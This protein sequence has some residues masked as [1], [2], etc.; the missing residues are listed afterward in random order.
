MLGFIG[1]LE[2]GPD[3]CSE[4][5]MRPSAASRTMVRRG[6]TGRRHHL[7]CDVPRDEVIK[8]RPGKQPD[9]AR[10]VG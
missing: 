6:G 4:L 2:G 8:E 7:K 9:I 10:K 3:F 5:S 1:L